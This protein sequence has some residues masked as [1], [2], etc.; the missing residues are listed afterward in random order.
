MQA[1]PDNQ[2]SFETA[3]AQLQ[4]II[5]QLDNTELPLEE[6]LR[7]YEEGKRLSALCASILENAQLR[8]SALNEVNQTPPPTAEE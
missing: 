1:T 8:V 2:P 4:T 7:L 3:F 5:T 6:A